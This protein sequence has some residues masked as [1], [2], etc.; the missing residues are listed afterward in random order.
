[1]IGKGR[2]HIP[3]TAFVLGGV[4]VR[5]SGWPF[6]LLVSI[7]IGWIFFMRQSW[8]YIAIMIFFCLFGYYYLTPLT[9]ITINPGP[10][11]PIPATISSDVK[12]TPQTIQMEVTLQDSQEKAMVILFNKQM[13]SGTRPPSWHHG[14]DCSLE[15]NREEIAKATNPGQFNYQAFLAN[16]EIYSQIEI[17]GTDGLLCNDRSFL[18][19]VYEWRN[20]LMVHVESVVDTQAYPW[21]AALI[22]GESKHLKE[23]TIEWFRD[24]NLSHILAISG[25]HVGL[26]IGGLYVLIYRTGLGTIEQARLLVILMLP[27]YCFLAGAAPSVVRASLMALLLLIFRKF[28]IKI[29][30]TDVLSLVAISL[31]LLSPG[32][33]TNIGFQFSFLVTM[34]LI[35]SLPIIEKSPFVF[36]QSAY[37]SLI[38]QMSI[39]PIQLS[40]FYEFNPLSLFANLL[41]VPYFSFIVIPLLL[42][43]FCVCLTTP[44]IASWLSKIIIHPHE[45][46]LHTLQTISTPFNIQWIVGELAPLYI[47]LYL[48]GFGYMMKQW[49][50]EN[51]L[52]SF[53]AGVMAICVLLFFSVLPYISPSGKVTMLDIGQGD[54]FVVELP[55]RRGVMIV[56]AGGPPVFSK[57]KNKT[58]EQ[59]ITPYLKSRGIRAIDGIIVSHKD[60][61]HSGS[62]QAMVKTFRVSKLF[63]SEYYKADEKG[64]EIVRLSPE[65]QV[66]IANH[67]FRVLYPKGDSGN[68]NDNSLVIWSE[69][70][71]LNW[72]FT[73]DISTENEEELMKSYPGLRADVLKVAHHGSNTSSSEEWVEWLKPRINLISAGR[74]NRYGHPHKEVT[75]R[76]EEYGRLYV[77]KDHGAVQYTFSGSSGTFSTFLPYNASRE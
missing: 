24:F 66:L 55:Y 57:D 54:C 43:L 31:L 7:G 40:Y 49:V 59:I 32:Y 53:T 75:L 21:M 6:W 65:D 69:I 50:A 14:A 3:V 76:L 62:V 37:I 67:S 70:G 17:E 11:G 71:G 51:L 77:T 60:V 63:V 15:G 25:L 61:D 44:G 1:M 64:V 68:P 20:S 46:I 74:D 12:E 13:E 4:L 42:L 8:S 45:Q 18:S 58:V 73:G 72:I 2:W 34:S 38:S 26:T 29:P 35:Y 52:K 23:S 56:D 5:L 41:I 47:I 10:T 28:N 30:I 9:P 19:Y 48:F 27:G 36:V 16:Q 22:F 33:F 39:L